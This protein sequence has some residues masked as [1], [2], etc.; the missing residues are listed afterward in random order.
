MVRVLVTNDDG[1]DAPGLGVLAAR[2]ADVADL[3]V[4]APD[5]DYSGSSAAFGRLW[6]H[7]PVVRRESVPGVD[8]A[9]SVAGPPALCV[10]YAR[11]GVFGDFDLVVSGI[12][13]GANVGRA[14]AHSGTVGA[15]VTGRLGGLSGIAVSQA[16]DDWAVIG[17]AVTDGSNGQLWATAAECAAV[18]AEALL[19]ELPAQPVVLNVN[20]PN[21]RIE[22]LSGWR[23][24]T[25]AEE[26]IR[27][28]DSVVL[29]PI[30][31][32][33]GAFHASLGW[34]EVVDLPVDTDGGAVEAG[35][36]SVTWLA[37]HGAEDPPGAAPVES[38]LS[39]LVP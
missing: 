8:E 33:P 37:P 25:I 20:V 23:R 32:E 11:H 4:V 14:V 15:V 19:A 35:Y 7:E 24:T 27:G 34:G 6:D 10:L 36:V 13:P 28:T 18:A 1:F 38:A 21:L 2:L 39:S 22:Q 16:V 5:R 12:N 26:P 30:E 3:A 31:A 29:Q 17:Q 9:W